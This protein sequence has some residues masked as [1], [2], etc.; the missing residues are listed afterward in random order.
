MTTA[1]E[2]EDG[3]LGDGGKQPV[4]KYYVQSKFFN[5]K[6]L[7]DQFETV[8]EQQARSR[9]NFEDTMHH[10][11]CIKAKYY[12]KRVELDHQQTKRIHVGDSKAAQVGRASK[13]YT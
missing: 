10:P 2:G 4:Y 13:R 8:D 9:P 5:K 1:E 11:D 7:Q 3:E 6:T 12:S